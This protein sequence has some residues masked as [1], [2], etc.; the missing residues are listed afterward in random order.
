MLYALKCPQN[1]FIENNDLSLNS[2]SIS[3]TLLSH[4]TSKML[5]SITDYLFKIKFELY[6]YKWKSDKVA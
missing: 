6:N 1:C 3:P 4:S 2:K 5:P